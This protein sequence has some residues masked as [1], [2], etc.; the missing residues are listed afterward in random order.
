MFA[1]DSG[2]QS[3]IHWGI[4]EA[5]KMSALVSNQVRRFISNSKTAPHHIIGFWCSGDAK[6]CL[7]VRTIRNHFDGFVTQSFSA[8]HDPCSLW[9]QITPAAGHDLYGLPDFRASCSSPSE[10]TPPWTGFCH[11]WVVMSVLYDALR[12][13][14]GSETTPYRA[15]AL[16]A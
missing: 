8:L 15:G 9:R 2:Q 1:T 3:T 10:G 14:M 6:D 11:R 12:T 7:L 4:I 5:N 16:Q 13:S